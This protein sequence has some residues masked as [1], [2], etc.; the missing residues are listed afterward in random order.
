MKK[1]LSST[2]ALSIALFNVQPWPLMAQT[3]LEDGS[4]VAI[5]GTVL[6]VPTAETMCDPMN[7]I[8]AAAAI[9]AALP[10]TEV[11][12]EVAVEPVPEVAVEPV[13]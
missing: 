6:C 7:F 2:T 13:P 9:E 10:P 11:V 4:V 5:D 8:E 3:L 1:L 12:P